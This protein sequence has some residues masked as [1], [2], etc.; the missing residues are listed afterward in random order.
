MAL[1][2]ILDLDGTLYNFD[3]DCNVNFGSSRFYNEVKERS[4]AFLTKKLAITPKEAEK[5]ILKIS[6]KNL[7][8]K[9]V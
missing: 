1:L 8:E 4:Y 3:G 6:K 9:L 7:Q 5:S 2:I